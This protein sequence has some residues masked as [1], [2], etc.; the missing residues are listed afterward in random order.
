MATFFKSVAVQLNS[1]KDVDILDFIDNEVNTT[2]ISRSALIKSAIRFY[3]SNKMNG[4]QDVTQSNPITHSE[5]ND[6][7]HQLMA[8]MQEIKDKLN[9]KEDTDAQVKTVETIQPTSNNGV[10]KV[11]FEDDDI[12]STFK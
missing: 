5:S 9:G 4:N 2:G 3:M 1:K 11:V 12:G 7:V 10:E 8:E 6:I